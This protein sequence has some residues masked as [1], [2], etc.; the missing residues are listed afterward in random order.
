MGVSFMQI[1]PQWTESGHTKREREGRA[2]LRW[3]RRTK[4][5]KLFPKRAGTS[6]QERADFR[7]TCGSGSPSQPEQRVLP[8]LQIPVKE[9]EYTKS[10]TLPQRIAPPRAGEKARPMPSK[11]ESGRSAGFEDESQSAPSRPLPGIRGHRF[12]PQTPHICT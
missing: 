4:G 3:D 10:P 6:L 12:K 7:F 5:G 9:G 11:R 1:T 2:L 8:N